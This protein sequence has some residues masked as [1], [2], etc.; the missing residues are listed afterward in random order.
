MR[1]RWRPTVIGSA[2]SAWAARSARA[3]L[4]RVAS[5]SS[6]WSASSRRAA[7]RPGWFAI[8]ARARQPAK[9]L[10]VTVRRSR[11]P[12]RAE[13]RAA[14]IKG[15]GMVSVGMRVD[16]ADNTRL[17]VLHPLPAVLSIRERGPVGKGRHNSDEAL[18][19]SRFLSAHAPPDPTAQMGDQRRPAQSRQVPTNDTER[20]NLCAG[21]TPSRTPDH[22]FA[23]YAT[24]SSGAAVSSCAPA[25]RPEHQRPAQH[26]TAAFDRTRKPV[27]RHREVRATTA[28]ANP[29][30]APP[31]APHRSSPDGRPD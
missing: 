9:E 2:C 20:V 6:P 12:R 21:Q 17:V 11:K 24:A 28:A 1:R 27:A 7:T 10:A 26:D 3:S 19:A 16:P 13:Q 23:G 14:L 4:G 8:C 18:V 22:I 15:G 25:G 30:R 31:P 29:D 5:A